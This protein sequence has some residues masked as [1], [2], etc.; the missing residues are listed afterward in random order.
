MNSMNSAITAVI[1]VNLVIIVYV[2]LAMGESDS[3]EAA[4]AG[5]QEVGGNANGGKQ[6]KPNKSAKAD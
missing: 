6:P 5:Q 3:D 4:C 2:V 1:L